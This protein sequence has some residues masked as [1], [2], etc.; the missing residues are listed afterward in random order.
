MTG[1]FATEQTSFAPPL[2]LSAD[3]PDLGTPGHHGQSLASRAR[4]R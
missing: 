4:L 3:R 2:K 1:L